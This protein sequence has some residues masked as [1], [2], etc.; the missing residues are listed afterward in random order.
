MLCDVCFVRVS[1][2]CEVM[3]TIQFTWLMNA[4]WC[5]INY[6]SIPMYCCHAGHH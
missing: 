4:Q 2:M 3:K 5:V 6:L 1:V